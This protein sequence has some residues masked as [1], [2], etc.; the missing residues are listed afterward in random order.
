MAR[1][2]FWGG[3]L[4]DKLNI[5]ELAALLKLPTWEK[6]D[7]YNFDYYWEAGAKWVERKEGESEADFEQRQ[8]DAEAEVRDDLFNRWYD[9]V[10]GAAEEIFDQHDLALE[11]IQHPRHHSDRPYEYRIVSRA[12]WEDAA[13]KIRGTID[14]VG[15]FTFYTL[16]AFLESGPYT[17]RQAVLSHLHWMKRRPEVYGTSSAKSLYEHN[18]RDY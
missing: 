4:K 2:P 8:M 7:D 11:P 1:K 13:E 10:H 9:A 14:G 6:L 17:A 5:D 18:F 12:S 15:E 16:R 3:P